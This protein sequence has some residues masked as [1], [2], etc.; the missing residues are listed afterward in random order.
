M[1]NSLSK[2]ESS[3]R[4]RDSVRPSV[5]IT[6]VILIGHAIRFVLAATEHLHNRIAKLSTRIRTLEDALAELQAQHSTEPHPLL[7]YDIPNVT[8]EG[9]EDPLADDSGNPVSN[10]DLINALGTL[11]ISDHGISHFFGPTGGSEVCHSLGNLSRT[12]HEFASAEF[13]HGKPFK[14]LNHAILPKSTGE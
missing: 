1:C 3:H 4:T 14:S 2:F 10:L 7:C 9:D 6:S 13:V 12:Q 8:V 5:C 11:S